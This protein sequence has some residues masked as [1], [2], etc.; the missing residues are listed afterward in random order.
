MVTSWIKDSKLQK[1]STSNSRNYLR[2]ISHQKET[3]VWQISKTFS[4]FYTEKL[5]FFLLRKLYNLWKNNRKIKR[6]KIKLYVSFCL[7]LLFSISV[8]P[9][10][11]QTLKV[12]WKLCFVW[13]TGSIDKERAMWTVNT[14]GKLLLVTLKQDLC[15]RQHLP[16][17]ALMRTTICRHSWVICGTVSHSHYTPCGL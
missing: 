10:G 5:H 6:K 3:N 7:S 4:I 8:Y 14:Y 2:K 16:H 12:C 17:N 1:M 15:L 11:V 9:N 13:L